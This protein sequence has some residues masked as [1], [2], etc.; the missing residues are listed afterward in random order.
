MST[1]CS[2]YRGT[3][4]AG[5][6]GYWWLCKG[7]ATVI[8]GVVTIWKTNEACFMCT[9]RVFQNFRSDTR[10]VQRV[11]TEDYVGSAAGPFRTDVRY[12]KLLTDCWHIFICI[13]MLFLRCWYSTQIWPVHRALLT[14]SER[15]T[16]SRPELKT[17]RTFLSFST[18][19]LPW[20]LA[21]DGLILRASF[22]SK[23]V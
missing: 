3:V 7:R 17:I 9:I 4:R 16:V 2:M 12:K 13:F 11:W 18:T 15:S 20:D 5:N 23:K 10:W 21:V 1:K 19:L 22:P 6:F 8:N 14:G